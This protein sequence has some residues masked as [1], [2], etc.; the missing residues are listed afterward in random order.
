MLRDSLASTDTSI[1]WCV[2]HR[3]QP[4]PGEQGD[5]ID[6]ERVHML[7]SALESLEVADSAERAELLALSAAEVSLTVDD[8]QIRPR[9]DEA[10]AMA[11]RVGDPATLAKVLHLCHTAMLVP[12]RLAERLA[13]TS[14]MIA[15]S[16]E[17]GDPSLRFQ[18]A[19]DRVLTATE[20]GEIEDATAELAIVE[21][22][23][24]EINDPALALLR[25]YVAWWTR[26]RC[27]TAR[28]GRGDR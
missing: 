15:I 28:R 7:A 23:A 14:E 11:Q 19:F 24:Q 4:R 17:L 8:D 10:I 22:L 5:E 16:L 21:D 18:A 13:T 1:N 6:E 2:Q 20:A 26:A 27:G 3:E 12:D 9:V 25:G